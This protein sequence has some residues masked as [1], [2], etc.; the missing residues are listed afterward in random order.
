MEIILCG[1]SLFLMPRLA[2]RRGCKRR[3]RNNL[4]VFCAQCERVRNIVAHACGD[5]LSR[6]TQISSE[7]WVFR[8]EDKRATSI[9]PA[10][11]T[12]FS[13]LLFSLS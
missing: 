3:A 13:C 4:L 7:S 10:L 12:I 1:L 6:Y 8:E 5:P 9:C 2:S 11:F